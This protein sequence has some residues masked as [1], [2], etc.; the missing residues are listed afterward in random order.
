MRKTLFAM[1]GLA[2]LA[3]PTAA[4]AQVTA[5]PGKSV[6]VLVM[7]KYVGT[8]RFAKFFIEADLGAEQAAKEL[9]NPIPLQFIGPVRGGAA[10][11]ASIITDVTAHGI[12]AIMMSNG[13]V[14][15]IVPALKAAQA[16][17]AKVVT[18]DFSVPSGEGEDLYVGQVDFMAGGKA[19]ADL[20]YKILGA[21]GGEVAVLSTTPQ[22]GIGKIWVGGFQEAMK[23]PKYA[24]FKQVD[25]AYGNDD[26]DESYKQ[27]LALVGKHPDLKLILVPASLPITAAAKAIQDKGLCD[28]VKI[29]GFGVPSEMQPYVH[30]G[31]SPVIALWSFY[32]LGYVAYYAAYS[33]ATN[34]IKAEEG[35]QFTAGRMGS[36][37]IAK[38][39]T[40][41]KGLRIIIAPWAFYDSSN[42]D[43]R[44]AQ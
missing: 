19:M 1:I 18:F 38:D 6:R 15:N 30:N 24:T 28:K 34:A 12:D 5:T 17:G 3:L 7:P 36:Y 13:S 39:P 21:E 2:L 20:A 44:A 25:I 42:I 26:F 35:Q 32:D 33:L 41:P 43:A 9:Q 22:S 37:T 27:T 29:S 11:Q 10:T 16:K 23:D 14:N 4:L 31:C 8:D 40:R